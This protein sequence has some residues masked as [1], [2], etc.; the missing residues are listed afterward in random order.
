[1]DAMTATISPPTFR[2]FISKKAT[3]ETNVTALTE[4]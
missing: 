1:M 3:A 2:S 4:P